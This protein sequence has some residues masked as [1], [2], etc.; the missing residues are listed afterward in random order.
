MEQK[1]FKD[2]P[3]FSKT[4]GNT[5][6]EVFNFIP[7]TSRAASVHTLQSLS[8]IVLCPCNIGSDIAVNSI[9]IL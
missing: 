2:L 9:H 1:V 6:I 5:K 7:C 3:F 4:E 8:A